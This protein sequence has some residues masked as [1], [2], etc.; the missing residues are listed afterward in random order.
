LG[1]TCAQ[2]LLCVGQSDCHVLDVLFHWPLQVFMHVVV[3]F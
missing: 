3:A 1:V 2:L